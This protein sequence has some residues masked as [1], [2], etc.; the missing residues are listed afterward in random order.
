MSDEQIVAVGL[1]TQTN[2]DM[3]KG[4]L[5]KVFPISESPCFDGLL[6]ALDEADR[7]YWREQDRKR[8]LPD[9]T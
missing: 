5:K 6:Q 1:L 9:Q 4:S 8:D 7:D 3:L 2:L